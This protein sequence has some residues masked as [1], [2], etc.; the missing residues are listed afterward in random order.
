M[1]AERS[2]AEALFAKQRE[3]AK[4]QLAQ[5]GRENSALAMSNARLERAL[6][7][8][9]AELEDIRAKLQAIKAEGAAPVTAADALTKQN[10]DATA[11]MQKLLVC[12]DNTFEPT[13]IAVAPCGSSNPLCVCAWPGDSGIVCVGT[14]AKEVYLMHWASGA[15]VA[16]IFV[17][18]PVLGVRT[19]PSIQGLEFEYILATCMDGSCHI[20]ECAV[21]RSGPNEEGGSAG[22]SYDAS[23]QIR[24]TWR[25][26]DSYILDARTTIST[27]KC[28]HGNENIFFCVTA[29]RDKSCV[30]SSISLVKGEDAKLR[31][32]SEREKVRSFF[33]EACVESVAFASPHLHFIQRPAKSEHEPLRIVVA[34]RESN[35]LTLCGVEAN[36]KQEWS[37]VGDGRP[38]S[39]ERSGGTMFSVLRLEAS[40]CGHFLLCLTDIH[41]HF[42]IGG[43]R[44]LRNFYGHTAD[45]MSTPRAAWHPNGRFVLGNSQK[46]CYTYV[47]CVASERIRV[48]LE[49]HARSIRDLAHHPTSNLLFTVSYDKTIRI[50]STGEHIVPNSQSKG[51][52][53]SSEV[54]VPSKH[55]TTSVEEAKTMLASAKDACKVAEEYVS[56]LVREKCLDA[57]AIKAA[58]AEARQARKSVKKAQHFLKQ[59]IKMETQK[60][61]TESLAA[62]RED[63]LVEVIDNSD[64]QRLD[65]YRNL[66]DASLLE[67]RGYFIAEGPEPLRLLLESKDVAIHSLLC[68]PTIYAKLRPFIEARGTNEDDTPVCG[69]ASSPVAV[70]VAT[71][72]IMGKVVGYPVK[73]GALACAERPVDRNEVWLRQYIL[74]DDKPFWRVLAVDGCNNTANL[75]SLMRTATAFGIDAVLLSSDCCDPWYRQAVRVSM[76]HV[77]RTPVV[78]V[79]NLAD[80]LTRLFSDAQMHSFGAVIDENS[81]TPKMNSLGETPPRWCGVVGNEDKGICFAVRSAIQTPCRIDMHPGVDSLSITVAA[82][83]FLNGLREREARGRTW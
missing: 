12:G 52:L 29:S 43:N 15:T 76:G 81:E 4:Q 6:S 23:M 62:L 82:G 73:R 80:T 27:S 30:V 46:D 18:G 24:L 42:V 55:V 32:A 22:K 40:P 14:A 17:S 70:F 21:S 65:K 41:K 36:E 3:A 19:F 47:W 37:F 38:C 67:R 64:D 25:D 44:V 45:G 31:I 13:P 7:E 16:S 54:K 5:L 35:S 53:P 77:F 57:L 74:R 56:K 59:T 69:G 75:G 33:F 79:P 50:W 66:K 60:Q 68:K 51:K 34:T 1:A 61:S 9:R 48:N 28:N 8:Q 2:S 10:Q 72:Q 83:V 26:H 58:K 49:G 63:P 20:I 11:L 78:R 71:H 39:L